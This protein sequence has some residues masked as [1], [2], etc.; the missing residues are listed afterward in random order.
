MRKESS[1]NPC[2]LDKT[3]AP[4]RKYRRRAS[5]VGNRMCRAMDLAV[6][7]VVDVGIGSN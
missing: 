6:P 7:L 5:G 4:G 1:E 2:P 3:I